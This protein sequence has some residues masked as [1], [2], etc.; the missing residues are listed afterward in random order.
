MRPIIVIL[1]LAWCAAISPL[2]AAGTT[3]TPAPQSKTATTEAEKKLGDETARLIE[4]EYTLVKDEKKLAHL[5]ALAAELAPL[6]ERPD[7]TYTCKILDSSE[8]NAM[9]IPG[10]TIY[11]TSGLMNAVESD[12]E[13]AA[14]MG[15]EMAHNALRHQNKLQNKEKKYFLPQLLIALGGIVAAGGSNSEVS[16]YQVILASEMVKQSLL[17]GYSKDVENEADY[18]SVQYLARSNH[19]DPVGL[20][21]VILGFRQM[22]NGTFRDKWPN[23]LQNHPDPKERLDN[24]KHEL[25]QLHWPRNLWHVVNFRASVV[26]PTTERPGYLLKLGTTDVATLL[27]ADGGADAGARAAAAAEAINRQLM[28]PADRLTHFDVH[29]DIQTGGNVAVLLL[30]KAPVLSLLPGDIGPTGRESLE[31]LAGQAQTN[32]MLAFQREQIRRDWRQID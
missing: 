14:V 6:T 29:L 1:V 30:R 5:I 25:Q 13:L 7:V 31:Q 21:S 4:K 11:F 15:H 2:L 26:P 22:E 18:H 12:D 27:A 9:A 3:A 19:Y 23:Y 20:Y 16:P 17:N 10:G 24:I 28:L 8:I 32:L